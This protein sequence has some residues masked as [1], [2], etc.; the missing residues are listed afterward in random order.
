[1]LVFS[2]KPNEKIPGFSFKMNPLK[3]LLNFINPTY[4]PQIYGGLALKFPN[5]LSGVYKKVNSDDFMLDFDHLI[6][7][8]QAL[9]IEKKKKVL[10]IN[11]H[12]SLY[13]Y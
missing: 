11:F 12:Y 13:L 5:L 7:E 10:Y 1:M 3:D 8:L 2:D 9:E 6:R 4:V